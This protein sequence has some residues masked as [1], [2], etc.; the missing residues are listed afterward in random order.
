MGPIERV[1]LQMKE[2]GVLEDVHVLHDE[3]QGATTSGAYRMDVTVVPPPEVGT[4]SEEERS[5]QPS[6]FSVVR[7]LI[8]LFSYQ[9][10]DR[11]LGLYGAFGYDLTFQFE[12]IDLKQTRDPEQ[13]DLLL[14][15]PDRIMV[16]DQDKR[17]AWK[18]SYEFAV[19]QE[20]TE[21]LATSG[22][23]DPFQP[24]DEATRDFSDR[25]TPKFEFANSVEKAKQEFKVGNLFE[26]VLS[27]TFREK[28]SDES[29][30]SVMFRR[31]RARNPAPYGFFINLG[32]QG[33]RGIRN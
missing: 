8:D 2:D 1:M 33:Y 17:D 14:Y 26:A 30:P 23:N 22:S 31:L 28:L 25:D 24:F 4:F 7:A 32:E 20:S 5:R 6:L 15:L 13:R 16:V 3:S 12:S 29:K 27:Q 10:G 18:L 21:G 11:Q 9:G 19:D